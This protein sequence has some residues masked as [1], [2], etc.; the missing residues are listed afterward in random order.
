MTY[1]FLFNRHKNLSLK[2]KS[3]YKKNFKIITLLSVF[4]VL[5]LTLLFAS[6]PKEDIK[7]LSAFLV[8]AII[9]LD[10]SLRFFFKKNASAAIIPYLTL[11]IP[12]KA[13]IF[14]I[15]A[16]DL[17]SF[18][19]WGCALIYDIILYYCRI[20][21]LWNVVMLLFFIFMNNYLIA[22]VKTL[23]GGYAILTYPVCA[24]F[25]F[26]ILLIAG[27]LSPVFVCF[28]IAAIVFSIIVALFFTLKENLHKELD[29]IAL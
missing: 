24:G 20:L 11:P 19:I 7:T 5:L 6:F 14:W 18:W 17:M 8:S 28:I 25:I 1:F 22:F 26:V 12:R 2:R 16:S 13:F 10:F 21:T 3:D 29:S 27:L 23:I 4:S 9:I 15:I